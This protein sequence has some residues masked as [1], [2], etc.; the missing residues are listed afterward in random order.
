MIAL[1]IYE[2]EI[3]KEISGFNVSLSLLISLIS[4]GNGLYWNQ[5]WWYPRPSMFWQV[6]PP[7]PQVR[8]RFGVFLPSCRISK[9]S[10]L[11]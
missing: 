1:S 5:Y 11:I 4:T 10:H 2:K 7:V 8:V 3:Q 9:I 6:S